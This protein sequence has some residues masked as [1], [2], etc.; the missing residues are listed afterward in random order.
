MNLIAF[1]HKVLAYLNVLLYFYI[2]STWIQYTML[3]NFLT[4]LTQYGLFQLLCNFVVLPFF[5]PRI[6]QLDFLSF[7]EM[8]LP[9]FL[10]VPLRFYLNIWYLLF[11]LQFL[12]SVTLFSYSFLYNEFLLISFSSFLSNLQENQPPQFQE[13]CHII[14]WRVNKILSEQLCGHSRSFMFGRPVCQ[15]IQR[16]PSVPI[17]ILGNELCQIVQNGMMLIFHLLVRLW[18]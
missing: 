17:L 18:M 6:I 14:N 1:L 4:L 5:R 15:Q 11:S 16:N 12:F 2:C 13:N 8:D 10:I 9:G 7:L 3:L